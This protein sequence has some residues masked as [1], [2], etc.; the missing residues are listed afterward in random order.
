MHEPG[1]GQPLNLCGSEPAREGID[2]IYL[3]DLVV[4]IAS[5][6]APTKKRGAGLRANAQLKCYKLCSQRMQAL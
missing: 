2:T 1:S 5:R 6:L 3:T 4:S